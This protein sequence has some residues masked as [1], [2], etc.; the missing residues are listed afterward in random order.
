M[1]IT[2]LNLGENRLRSIV[3]LLVVWDA[4]TRRV[5]NLNG[6]QDQHVTFAS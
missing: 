1:W 4:E 6:L 5:S 2:R 3:T